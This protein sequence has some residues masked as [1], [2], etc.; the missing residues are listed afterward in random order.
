MPEISVCQS[1][2][3]RLQSH[4]SPFVDSPE[5]VILRALDTLEQQVDVPAVGADGSGSSEWLI[6]PLALPLL[7][8]TK[9][10]HA[11]IDGERIAKPKW[12]QLLFE[13]LRKAMDSVGSFEELPGIC[14]VNMVK[15]RKDDEG[16]RYVQ[17]ID[18][19]VQGLDAN[20][21]CRAVIAAAQA[22]GISLDI[23]FMWR[24]KENAAYPGKRG[25]IRLEGSGNASKIAA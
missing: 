23:G 4:A 5:T 21:A 10:L 11:M 20:G 7:T 17:D 2:F 9:L 15:G 14:P 19:S 12:N 16:Y 8:H 6:D 18:I 1:T 25:R 13:S 3:E 22:L 24:L